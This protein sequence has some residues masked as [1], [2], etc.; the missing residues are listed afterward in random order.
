MNN[1]TKTIGTSAMKPLR[2]NREVIHIAPLVREQTAKLRVAGY[3][4]VSSDSDDQQNSFSAQLRYYTTLITANEK[5]ELV[6]V[7]TDEA[8]TGTSTDKR[9][10]FNRMIADCKKGKIDRILTKSTSRF[11]RN[12]MDSL[13]TVRSLKEIGV[14]V[15][16]EKESLDTDKISSGL[17]L[18]LY[19]AFSQDESQSHSQNK[20]RGNRMQMRNGTYVSSS[21]PYGYRLVDKLPQIYEPEAEVVR[22]IFAE[23][24]N[25][26]GICQIAKRLTTDGISRRDGGKKWRH[27]SISLIIQN[28]RF[29]GDMLLQK[30]FNTDTLP[31]TKAINHGELDKYYLTDTHEPIIDR[32]QYEL[33]NILLKER[34]AVAKNITCGEYPLSKKIKCGI[35]GTTYKRKVTNSQIYWVCLKHDEDRLLCQSERISETEIYTA[36]VRL[37]NK[38]RAN[39]KVILVPMLASLEKMREARTRNNPEITELNVQLAQLSEQNH[40]MNGLMS[41]GILDSALFIAQN[42]ELCR[43]IKGLKLAKTRLMSATAGD[44]I[45][46]KAEELI[47]ILTDG[48]ELIAEFDEGLFSEMVKTITAKNGTLEFKLINGLVLTETSERMTR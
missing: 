7:Y 1:Q 10:D 5:W 27:Q 26:N 20:K 34:G 6:D 8:V 44:G 36:F 14:S 39:Y 30:S 33:A 18:T 29:I 19:S 35:C 24:L 21:V 4:R 43:K 46:E 17:L 25:G 37:Y 48:P 42:D 47:D 12:T 32:V 22:R 41:R 13:Q 9:D 15:L 11:A 16:F 38:L 28:E 3:A 31:Y 40:V 2:P 45:I 23:Y